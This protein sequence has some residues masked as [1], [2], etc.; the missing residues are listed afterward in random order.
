MNLR[1][2]TSDLLG[3]RSKRPKHVGRLFHKYIALFLAVICVALVT[4]GLLEVYFSF[5]DYRTLWVTIQRSQAETAAEKI[6]QFVHEI[7]GQMGWT[8]QLPWAASTVDDWRFDA[9]RLFRQVPAITEFIKLD[10]AGR[11]QLHVSR[12]DAD[13]IGS[14]ADFSKDPKFVEAMANKVHYG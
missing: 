1:Q 7:E 12:I 2:R 11:E 10:T 5:R 3:G 14:Q 6:K 8:T 9:A 4:D 13:V